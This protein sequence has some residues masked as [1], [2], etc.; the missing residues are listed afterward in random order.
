MIFNLEVTDRQENLN[1]ETS[2]CWH[3]NYYNY[4]STFVYEVSAYKSNT[5]QSAPLCLEKYIH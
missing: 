3:W 5:I 1:L 2:E 4:V